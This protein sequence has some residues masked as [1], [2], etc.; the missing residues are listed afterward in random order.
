[1]KIAIMQPTFL[2]WLGYFSLI[3]S[4]DKFVFLDDVQF[5]RRSWQQRNYILNNNKPLLLTVPVIKKGKM[6]QPINCVAIDNSSSF[7]RNIWRAF[8]H[9]YLSTFQKTAFELLK[10]TYEEDITLLSDFNIS[11]ISNIINYLD[12]KTEIICSS[13]LGLGGEKTDRLINICV[14]LGCTKY[15]SVKGSSAYLEHEQFQENNIELNYFRFISSQNIK[16]TNSLN[17]STMHYINEHN[18]DFFSSLDEFEHVAQ[19][20]ELA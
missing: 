17:L 1:M 15:V 10:L 4:V 6:A 5:D 7:K 19:L 9:A 3:K 2:P 18:L 16:L 14:A 12:I 13:S 20:A 11:L 8:R